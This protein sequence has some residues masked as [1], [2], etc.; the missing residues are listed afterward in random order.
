[1][2]VFILL[3]IGTLGVA[4]PLLWVSGTLTS[5]VYFFRHREGA[6]QKEG[7]LSLNPHLGLTMAD[8]GDPIEKKK[9][10]G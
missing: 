8:G 5:I 3:L 7:A 9:E 6:T 10:Q 1:M 2:K 4:I